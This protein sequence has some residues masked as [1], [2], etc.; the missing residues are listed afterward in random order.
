L[1]RKTP[2]K[3]MPSSS[4]LSAGGGGPL[5]AMRDLSRVAQ[6]KLGQD[7]QNA[8]VHIAEPHPAIEGQS[9]TWLGFSNR[10][11]W[12]IQQKK[13][14]QYR[15]A[16]ALTGGLWLTSLNDRIGMPLSNRAAAQ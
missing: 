10:W 16:R 9:K 11:Q 6:L 13:P 2:L 5:L 15:T 12:Q 8:T 14:Q 3:Q 4:E 1:H 7:L